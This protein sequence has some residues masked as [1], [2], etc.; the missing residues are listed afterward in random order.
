MSNKLYKKAEEYLNKVSEK[1]KYLDYS[2]PFVTYY[3]KSLRRDE[4]YRYGI[5]D[6]EF[7]NDKIIFYNKYGEASKVRYISDINVP[8]M[9]QFGFETFAY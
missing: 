1:I 9:N 6:Y 8:N 4:T 7:A 3:L 5:V 2:D